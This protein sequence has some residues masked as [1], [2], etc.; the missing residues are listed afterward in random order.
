M[1]YKTD[2]GCYGCMTGDP[3]PYPPIK[4]PDRVVDMSRYP[5]VAVRY[6]NYCYKCAT[7][8]LTPPRRWWQFWKWFFKDEWKDWRNKKNLS[9]LTESDMERIYNELPRPN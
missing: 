4:I 8:I 7:A 6:K 5:A 3:L 2:K 9:L 1:K